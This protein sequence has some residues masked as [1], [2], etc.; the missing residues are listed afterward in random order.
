M[1]KFCGC[2]LH[3]LLIGLICAI[4]IEISFCRADTEV[5][6]LKVEREAL[7]RFRDGLNDPENR[8]SSW[9]G[10][11]CCRWRGLSC[12]NRSGNVI[13]LDLRN[14]YPNDAE[15]HGFWNLSG[16]VNSSLLELKFLRHLDLSLNTFEDIPIPEFIGSLRELGY[17]KS[18]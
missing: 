13:K 17:L 6:C 18:F 5:G 16:Q 14:P 11:D 4:C 7:I 10:P 8:L 3:A 2:K 1:G 9:Q 12:D 15:T